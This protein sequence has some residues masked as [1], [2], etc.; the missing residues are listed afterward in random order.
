MD[1]LC[2][3]KNQLMKRNKILITGAAG[4]LGSML[5]TR[6]VSMNYF[7]TAVDIL[8]YDKNSLSHLF[9]KKNFMEEQ[10]VMPLQFQINTRHTL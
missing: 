4:Y 5:A 9:G 6:L 3:K 1:C 10:I 7:V 2:D 8:K